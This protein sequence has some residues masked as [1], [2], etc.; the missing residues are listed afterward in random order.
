MGCDSLKQCTRDYCRRRE[1]EI[2]GNKGPEIDLGEHLRTELKCHL[3]ELPNRTFIILSHWVSN[4][5]ANLQFPKQLQASY[6]DVR[7]WEE[8]KN[9][10]ENNEDPNEPYILTSMFKCTFKQNKLDKEYMGL[11]THGQI[12][13]DPIYRQI[14]Y[15]CCLSNTF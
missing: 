5:S 1:K 13:Y 2:S 9:F 11:Y 6:T 12:M 3:P 4:G 7:H 15:N 14:L 10:I 8:L